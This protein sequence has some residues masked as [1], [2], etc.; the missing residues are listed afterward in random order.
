MQ[1]KLRRSQRVT[2]LGAVLFCVDVRADYS[3][4]ESSHITRY[5][6]GTQYIYNSRKRERRMEEAS[7]H[8]DNAQAGTLLQRAASLSRGVSSIVVASFRLQITVASLANGHHIACKDLQELL[9]AEDAVRMAAR[10]LTRWLQIASTF[11]GSE[12]VIE[13]ENGQEL[14]RTTPSLAALIENLSARKTRSL[15]APP[16]VRELLAPYLARF[17]RWLRAQRPVLGD[18]LV[19]WKSVEAWAQDATGSWRWQ[20]GPLS[21]RI[22]LITIAIGSIAARI[23]L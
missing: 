20:P 7:A 2:F 3:R 12:M 16:T 8:L 23:V 18:F 22:G 21:I 13:Y 19:W 14:I 10:K 6:L 17:E 5:R 9:D 15:Q 4:E 11:D 1:L